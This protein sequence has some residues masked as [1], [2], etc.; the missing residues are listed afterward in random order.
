MR[1][2][3][4]ELLPQVRECLGLYERESCAVLQ[5]ELEKAKEQAKALGLED[6]AQAPKVKELQERYNA[7]FDIKEAENEVFS[8]LY[9]FFRRYYSEGDFIS[10]RRYKE[11]YEK[12][13]YAIPYH[14]EEVKLYWANYDQYY[15]KTSEYLRNY[16]FKLPSG[17]RVHFK[18]IEADTEKDNNRPQNGKER[19]FILSEKQPFAEEN[20]ELVIRFEYRPDP[21]KRKQADL[22]AEAVKRILNKIE[23]FIEQPPEE[24]KKERSQEELKKWQQELASLQQELTSP[25]SPE[26]NPNRTPEK[27]PN[28][29]LLGKHLTDYTARNTFDYFIHKD[30]GGFLRRELD[31]YIKNEVMHLDDI[32]SDTAPR[33]E[34][35]LSK[36]KAIRR[37][38]HKIIDFLAQLENFQKKLWLKKKFVVET[39]YCVTLDRV[40]EELY[41]Q[42]AAN[43]EQRKEW[44]RLFAID[45]LED[46]LL[47]FGERVAG[48]E[49]TQ[50]KSRTKEERSALIKQFAR[51]MR[52]APTDAE[53]RL[54]YFLRDRRLGGYKFRRQHPVGNYIADFACIEGRLIVE[55]D[56]GHHAEIFQQEKDKVK[57]AFFTQRGFRVLRFWNHQVLNDTQAVLEEILRVLEESPHPN[58]L[59]FGEREMAFLKA[60]PYLVLDTRHFSEDFK[61]RLLASFDDLD[62]Q[63]DGLLIHSENFQALNILNER[64]ASLIKTAY[65]DPPYNTSEETFVYKNNY[66]HSSWL[67]MMHDRIALLRTMLSE[68]GALIV[69]ID[70]AELYR[71]KLSVDSV[72]G[73]DNYLG[74]IVVQSNPRGR[75]INSYYATSHDYYLVYAADAAS[76]KIIDQPLTEEQYAEY[77]HSDETSNY[78]LLPFRRSGGL[79]TPDARPNSEF[80]LYYSESLGRIIGVGS[81][82]KE[83]YPAEYEPVNILCV[84]GNTFEISELSPSQFWKLAPKD[85]IEI[86]PIDSD[87]ARRVWRWSDRKKI[88]QAA[89]AKELLV[90]NSGGR[91]SVLLKDRIKEGRKPK[92]V[93][94]DSKY[95]ASSHGTNLLQDILGNRG[96]FGYP[97][98]LY[99]TRDAIHSIAGEDEFAVIIDAFAGSGTTAHAVINLN[100]EDGGRRKYILVEMG[101]YFD[102][103]LVPRIKKVVYSKDWKDGKPL[104]PTLS[105]EGRRQ[106]EGTGISHMFKYIRLESYEDTLNNL[107]NLELKRIEQLMRIEQQNKKLS[108]DDSQKCSERKSFREDYILHYMLEVES[109]GSPSLL[110]LD[111]FEDPFSYELNIATGTVGETKP[112]VIDLVETFNYLI[113]LRVKTIRYIDG[114]CVVTGTNPQ[115]ERVLILWRNTKEMDND[116]LDEWFKK[117][118]YRTKGQEFDLIYV[119]G[120]NNLENLKEPDQTWRVRLIEE[121]FRVRMFD[122]QDV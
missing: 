104:T 103:V 106:G 40:P 76:V 82:R 121:E 61:R 99:S 79:S 50:I 3:D 65:L 2:F 57:T 68:D 21:Q 64:F 71:L 15:I 98:S 52:H 7:A 1:F 62:E 120:D 110:N 11:G 46:S 45:K 55:L 28:R 8:H 41:P 90:Q 26:K 95:D 115:G 77:R 14:G 70:D 93:W 80:T 105:P 30:L 36:I 112:T 89:F 4:E 10:Q 16:T 13:P 27:H 24:F 43:D 49:Q 17:K 97:K 122:L 20:G 87:G 101:E 58:P 114:V 12:G 66:R 117:Q 48:E 100:R 72:L 56:G 37:I 35:Y 67:A 44:V 25:W 60:N 31:F 78:R 85:T 9:N 91:I 74:T 34:Q 113:G 102:T 53:Q 39:Q 6:P 116:K 96:L 84:F 81:E 51:E 94:A 92:T 22:N 75:G 83:D 18:L 33:V 69:A 88:L 54:W 23:E 59:P 32:E 5:A 47:P 109:R 19:R 111:R 38:A 108:P 73:E 63:C 119:N 118:G 107:N 86:L 42:I 29:T